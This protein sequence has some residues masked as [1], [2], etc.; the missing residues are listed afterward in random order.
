MLTVEMPDGTRVQFPDGTSRETM[1]SALREKFPAQSND[2]AAYTSEQYREAA[3]KALAAGDVAAAKRLI[4]RGRAAESA[5]KS[6][7]QWGKEQLFGDNDPSTMNAGEKLG[8]LLNMGGN[9]L[10]F[11]LVGDEAAAAADSLIGRGG[12]DDRLA[13]YRG[14]EAAVRE[15]NPG[16]SLAA[17]VLPALAAPIGALGTGGKLGARMLK[18]GLA[19]G[20]LSGVAGFANA[21]GGAGQRLQNAYDVAPMGAVIGGAIPIVGSALQGLMQS[22]MTGR[23]I[24]AGAKNAPSSDELRAMGNAAYQ[25]VD[26]AGVQIAPQAFD[27]ARGGILDD[28]RANTGFDELPGPGSLTP[29]AARAS[30]IMGETSARMGADPTAALPF[31]ALDQMRRQAGAAAGNVTNKTD[32][33]AGMTII[34]GLDDFI[35]N[36]GPN[37][38]VAGDVRALQDA[39]PKARETWSRM[40]KSQMIDS[41]IEA[42]GN[43]TSGASSGIRNQFAAILRDKKAAGRFTE[44]ERAAMRRVVNG[45]IPEQL[46]NLASGGMGQI[47]QTFGGGAAGG[48][49]GA[50]AGAG[51]AAGTRKLA[52]GVTR[53]KAE[54]V[55]GLVANGGL[56]N[57]P[58]ASTALRDLLE[59][60]LRLGT[61]A[62]QG[63]P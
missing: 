33:K 61:A 39:I 15:S 41:A 22:R 5:N 40:S 26:N 42:G 9:A 27:R 12:Y 37:D 14:D 8:T 45:S 10:T 52:E 57:L 11:G 53:R 23:A 38:V 47:A 1:L 46:L 43:Y 3:K 35:K 50:F 30:Q 4:A 63:R 48:I 28:L 24:K 60:R 25:Q 58:Q 18:S 34:E 21:E 7:G 29:Y 19:T 13:K 51:A 36:L 31:K 44:G 55:R 17:D 32:Q 54:T 62:M 6:W 20:A 16:A 56:Q 49:P 59:S 2:P